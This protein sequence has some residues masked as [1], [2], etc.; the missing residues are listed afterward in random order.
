[1]I[2]HDIPEKGKNP[3]EKAFIPLLMLL[4]LSAGW[5]AYELFSLQKASIPIKLT[6]NNSLA[7]SAFDSSS[8]RASTTTGAYVASKNG[9]AYYLVTCTGAKRILD[10]NKVFFETRE[11]A[12]RA[13]FQAAKNCPGL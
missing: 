10:K 4:T 8:V 2:I 6:Y 11:A 13:G 12:E 9:K 7:A 5:G 3:L 1:M